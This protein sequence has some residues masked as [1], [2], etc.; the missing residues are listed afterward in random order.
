MMSSAPPIDLPR[1]M[2][3][4]KVLRPVRRVS[5]ALMKSPSSD[6]GHG[7]FNVQS[8]S[9]LYLLFRSVGNGNE[10]EG[11]D[12]VPRRSTSMILGGGV[13]SYRARM[14]FAFLEYLQVRTHVNTS[15]RR[16]HTKGSEN[17][18]VLTSNTSFS[19]RRYQSDDTISIFPDD[20][21]G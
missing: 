3:L 21:R 2:T 8:V 17:G 7:T 11:E 20:P 18:T 1:R 19:K 14:S 10:P 6:K 13:K 16:T 9:P 12:D 4:G 15:I 5:T